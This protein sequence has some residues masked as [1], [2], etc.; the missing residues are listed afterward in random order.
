MSPLGRRATSWASSRRNSTSSSASSGSAGREPVGDVAR[1]AREPHALAVVAAVRS[2]H[3]C[4][5]AV[6]GEEGVEFGGT[7]DGG[8]LGHREAELR[9]P[10]AHGEL[11]LGVAQRIRSGSHRDTAVDQGAQHLLRH[12]LVVEGDHVRALG[13]GG[14]G[15]EIPVVPH[16]C[17]GERSGGSLSLGEHPQLDAERNG[18]GDHHARELAATDDRDG[19]RHPH[20]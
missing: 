16:G 8:P 2:L 20:S 6:R 9:Q 14:D 11:V 1:G 12:V 13:E 7:R 5:A 19:R 17:R 10:G 18:W 4:D 3:D 15:R